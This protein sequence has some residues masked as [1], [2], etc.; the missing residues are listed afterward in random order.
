MAPASRFDRGADASAGRLS[1][2][3]PDLEDLCRRQSRAGMIVTFR[4][5]EM[6]RRSSS[7]IQSG[8]WERIRIQGAPGAPL[9]GDPDFGNVS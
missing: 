6:I 3:R 1:E 7:R 4:A 2:T 5:P 9:L 8:R